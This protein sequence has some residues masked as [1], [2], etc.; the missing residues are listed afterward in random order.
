MDLVAYLSRQFI[1]FSESNNE[2]GDNDEGQLELA[3]IACIDVV[4]QVVGANI[5]M[6]SLLQIQPFIISILQEAFTFEGSEY[7]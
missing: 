7:I 6:D 3:A 5:G 2:V 1:K 4:R